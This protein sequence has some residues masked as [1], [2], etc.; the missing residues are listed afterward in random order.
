MDNLQKWFT[1]PESIEIIIEI[2]TKI[3]VCNVEIGDSEDQLLFM[4]LLRDAMNA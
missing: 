2:I 1:S 4:D 3:Q